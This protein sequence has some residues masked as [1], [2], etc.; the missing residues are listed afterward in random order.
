MVRI[1]FLNRANSGYKHFFQTW[2]WFFGEVINTTSSHFESFWAFLKNTIKKIY[3]SIPSS[4][5]IYFVKEAELRYL[6]REK[7]N[8]EFLSYLEKIFKYCYYSLSFNFCSEDDQLNI[9]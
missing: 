6:L 2:T 4:N 3:H 8:I 7:N 9:P 5:L 1:F